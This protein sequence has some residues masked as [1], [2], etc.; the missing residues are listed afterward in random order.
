MKTI[1][2]SGGTGLIG[3]EIQKEFG[4]EHA[5]RI[6]SRR[7]GPNNYYWDPYN[8]EIDPRALEGVDVVINLVGANVFAKRWSSGRKKEILDSRTIPMTFLANEIEEHGAHPSLI[9]NASGTGYYG[10]S[11]SEEPRIE[12]DPMGDGFL[13]YV[14]GEWENAGASFTAPI[15]TL[16]IAMVLTRLGGALGPLKMVSNFGL[17]SPIGSGNQHN[18]WIHMTDLMGIIRHVIETGQTGVFNCAAPDRTPQKVFMKGIAHAMRRPFWPIAV[19]G[20]MV[21]LVLGKRSAMALMGAPVSSEKIESSGYQFKYPT[22]EGALTE[23]FR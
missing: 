5:I 21:K 10:S 18:P 1:L 20:F 23:I 13:A 9:I 7:K 14:C 6:L 16:R 19:P 12:S 11:D 4:G 15:T 2:I 8:G 3:K 17:A 22:L